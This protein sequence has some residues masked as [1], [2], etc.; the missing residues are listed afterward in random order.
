M[1]VVDRLR[2]VISP[3]AA[4]DIYRTGVNFN[5]NG[6][7]NL[8]TAGFIDPRRVRNVSVAELYAGQPHLQTVVSFRALNLAQL[9]IQLYRIA[10]GEHERERGPLAS[11]MAEP[12]IYQTGFELMQDLSIALDLY[13]RA[14]WAVVPDVDTRSGWSIHTLPVDWVAKEGGTWFEPARYVVRPPHGGEISLPSSNVVEFRGAA[15]SGVWPVAPIDALREILAEQIA[16]WQYRGESWQRGARLQSYVYRPAG[17]PWTDKAR[18]NFT[19]S[20]HEF[21]ANGARAGES[22][23][24][25]DGMEVRKIGFSAREDEWAEVARL[26]LQTVCSVY[27]VPPAMVG[28]EGTATY[29]SAREFRSMLYTETLGPII[30]EIEQRINQFVM[31][32]VAPD[33]AELAWRFNIDAKLAGSFEE[34]ASVLSTATGAPWMTV[35]E[36]RGLRNLPPLP[37]GDGLVVPLNVTVGGQASPQDGGAPSVAV[38]NAIEAGGSE[39]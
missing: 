33:D 22:P 35:N 24:L 6:P 30:R 18:K 27:H 17:Q 12:N 32:I 20:W 25:E 26:S 11:L 13:G 28:A 5:G 8:D 37:E 3:A 34:Q 31:R 23:V 15:P 9:P 29:A 39:D 19:Q 36:A 4:V 1:G 7:W 2:R 16:A 38:Q 10:D 21:Q 14:F